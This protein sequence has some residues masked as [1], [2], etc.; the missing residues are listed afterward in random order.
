MCAERFGADSFSS[1]R[2]RGWAKDQ[3]SQFAGGGYVRQI[4]GLRAGHLRAT[5]DW[6]RRTDEWS[7]SLLSLDAKW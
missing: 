5:G 3:T 7:P 1:T 2:P 6:S 4:H